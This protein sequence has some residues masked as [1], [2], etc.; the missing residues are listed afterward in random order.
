MARCTTPVPA[1]EFTAASGNLKGPRHRGPFF[2]GIPPL[3]L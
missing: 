3:D 2:V 1:I